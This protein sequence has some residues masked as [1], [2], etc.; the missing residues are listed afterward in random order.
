M[1]IASIVYKKEGISGFYGNAFYYFCS[2]F[3]ILD[4]Y[5]NLKIC[6]ILSK[7]TLGGVRGVMLGNSFKFFYLS[8][9]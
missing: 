5:I 2:F 8:G 7:F 3:K 1:E 4:V 9:R 6:L